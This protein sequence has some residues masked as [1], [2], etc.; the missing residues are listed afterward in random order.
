MLVLYVLN[1]N[2]NGIATSPSCL[3]RARSE[4][5]IAHNGESALT[6]LLDMCDTGK[7]PSLAGQHGLEQKDTGSTGTHSYSLRAGD[8]EIAGNGNDSKGSK[9]KNKKGKGNKK[10]SGKNGKE[11]QPPVGNVF[12]SFSAL[13]YTGAR[14]GDWLKGKNTP[15]YTGP[16]LPHCPP[17]QYH[18]E[19]FASSLNGW[20]F[21]SFSKFTKR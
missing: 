8:K 3:C 6:S 17:K 5:L 10:Q 16:E 15:A 14:V 20:G 11:N 9:G 21:Q 7:E 12:G 4:G 19:P 1:P 2:L 13:P 18:K